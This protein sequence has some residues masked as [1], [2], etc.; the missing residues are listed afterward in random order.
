MSQFVRTN[1][2][3]N[4]KDFKR[5]GAF[6]GLDEQK[7][8]VFYSFLCKLGLF[9][10]SRAFKTLVSLVRVVCVS[11]ISNFLKKPIVSAENALKVFFGLGLILDMYGS[12]VSKSLFNMSRLHCSLENFRAKFC[13]YRR[14]CL[15]RAS[16]ASSES[17]PIGRSACLKVFAWLV[18]SN[19]TRIN[20]HKV[21]LF[22]GHTQRISLCQL[23]DH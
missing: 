3:A 11:R 8:V 10:H 2:Q 20:S 9:W 23:Y 17:C 19:P 15:L 21:L 4:F 1:R 16:D 7:N 18:S 13:L 12:E 14:K 5:F 22:L 6:N